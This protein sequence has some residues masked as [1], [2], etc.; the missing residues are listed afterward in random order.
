MGLDGKC[1]IVC[2]TASAINLTE[3]RNHSASLSDYQS[4]KTLWLQSDIS[5]G[6]VHKESSLRRVLCHQARNGVEPPAEVGIEP[7][8]R[9]TS[10]PR[11][12]R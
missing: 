8:P 3:W 2:R 11:T 10:A 4:I 7:A 1:P 6:S 5:I 12:L 9:S